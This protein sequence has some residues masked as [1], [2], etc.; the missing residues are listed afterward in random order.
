[1]LEFCEGAAIGDLWEL[2][3]SEM[4]GLC[5]VAA[6]GLYRCLQHGLMLVVSEMRNLA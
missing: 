4:V 1:M 5:S 2:K 6:M 3:N